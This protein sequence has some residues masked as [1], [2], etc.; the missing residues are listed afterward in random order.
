MRGVDVG[1]VFAAEQVFHL[2]YFELALGEAGVTAVGFALVANGGQSVRIDGQAEQFA[3]VLFQGRR[4]LQALHVFFSQRVIGGADAVLHGHIKAS[5]RL[6]ATRYADQNQI[7]LV[8]VMRARTVV[9]VQGKVH[10]LDALHV[11]GGVANGVR[12]AHRIG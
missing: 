12:L 5:R 6:A 3:F 10:R 8:V 11:I 7:G 1:D 2:T 4:Q 9:I